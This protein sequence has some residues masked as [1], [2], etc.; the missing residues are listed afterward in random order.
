MLTALPLPQLGHG[1]RSSNIGVRKREAND[2]KWSLFSS[3]QPF[4]H[5]CISPLQ[6]LRLF[7]L[8]LMSRTL[9]RL[10]SRGG[11]F[12]INQKPH[13]APLEFS[14]HMNLSCLYKPV[15]A[16]L[17]LVMSCSNSRDWRLDWTSWEAT[18]PTDL[19]S[20]SFYPMP[21]VSSISLLSTEL[22]WVFC[23]F[24]LFFL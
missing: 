3:V 11:T 24:F 1:K 23:L 5:T 22:A 15:S 19:Q 21:A 10:G 18:I 6:G 12:G 20:C 13:S 4:L 9:S 17:P 14:E 16:L 7:S 2:I 8:S